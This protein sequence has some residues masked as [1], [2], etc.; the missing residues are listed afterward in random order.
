MLTP[1]AYLMSGDGC[2]GT[3]MSLGGRIKTSAGRRW[4]ITLAFVLGPLISITAAVMGFAIPVRPNCNAA[5]A[6]SH[7]QVFRSLETTCQ[8]SALTPKVTYLAII[9]CGIAIFVVACV[10]R[11]IRITAAERQRGRVS[12]SE[13]SASR[14]SRGRSALPAARSAATSAPGPNWPFILGP[15]IGVAGIVM[16]YT[17]PVGPYCSGAFNG[18]HMEAAGYDI[19]YA[20]STGRQGGMSD[21]C[22]AAAPGQTGIYWGIIGFGIAIVILG[23]VLRSVANRQ[24]AVVAAPAVSV[25]EELNRL[26]ILRTRGILTDAEFEAQK[27]QLLRR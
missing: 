17:I 13:E 23:A 25:A 24:P 18:N 27:G 19:A 16:G 8:M 3:F 7:G 10:L 14:R 4:P 5:F 2:A 12:E 21:A 26:D 1:A 20:T 11:L 15:L 22:S 9:G 6:A